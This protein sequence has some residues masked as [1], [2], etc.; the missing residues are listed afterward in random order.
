MCHMG[1]EP[2]HVLAH[3]DQ[4]RNGSERPHDSA[5]PKGVGD[6]LS[7]AVAP[8]N[9]E[10]GNRARSVSADLNHVYRIGSSIKGASTIGRGFHGGRD[11]KR[12]GDSPRNNFGGL[13]AV[14]VDIEQANRRV[15]K[16]RK[17]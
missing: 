8:W 10:I 2:F 7:K 12:L 15:C 11:S 3:I 14:L 4:N 1:T 5:N 16:L 13:K 17:G 9:F 6:R